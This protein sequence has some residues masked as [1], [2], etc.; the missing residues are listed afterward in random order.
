MT[1]G[2]HREGGDTESLIFSFSK[3]FSGFQMAIL[4]NIPPSPHTRPEMFEADVMVEDRKWY[5]FGKLGM[6]RPLLFDVTNGGWV[7]HARSSR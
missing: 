1:E 7:S 3:L 6:V 5:A 4:L 2:K